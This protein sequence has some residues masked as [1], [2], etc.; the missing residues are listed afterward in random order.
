ME[1][2]ESTKQMQGDQI[3]NLPKTNGH[4]QDADQ[5]AVTGKQDI[6]AGGEKVHEETHKHLETSTAEIDTQSAGSSSTGTLTP[7]GSPATEGFHDQG[8]SEEPDTAQQAKAA[9]IK[10]PM[11]TPISEICSNCFHVGHVKCAECRSIWYCSRE[12]QRI[13]WTFHKHLCREVKKFQDR[14]EPESV[15]A[16]FF[17]ENDKA[18]KF[19]W[20]KQDDD[21]LDLEYVVEKFKDGEIEGLLSVADG[22][23]AQ[24]YVT[25]SP[26]RDQ[27]PEN[28]TA[29]MYLFHRQNL[30]TDGS[31][32][33]MSV[34]WVTKGK[35]QFSW[36]G[37]M[38][39]VLTRF[40]ASEEKDNDAM[41][42]DISMVDFRDLMDFFGSY[43]Q[44]VPSYGDFGGFSFFW[45][46]QSLK[47]ELDQQRRIKIVQ[48][49]SEIDYKRTG[50]KYQEGLLGEGHPAMAYLQP[51]PVTSS[52][53]LPLVLRR[54]PVDDE[55]M[56]EVQKN[57]QWNN[58]AHLLLLNVDPKSPHWGTTPG[59]AEQGTVWVM[60]HDGK[61]LY[62]YH[63]QT[64]IMYLFQ[65]VSEAMRESVE[66]RRSKG[67]VLDL[68]H[69]S[70]LDWYFNK[71]RK[72]KAEKDKGWKDVRPLFE[73]YPTL[74][75]IN[76]KLAG[77]GVKDAKK[78]DD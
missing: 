36:R 10:L 73:V 48:I 53:G 4:A 35:F 17:P 22:D 49:A 45:M 8:T 74:A 34:G 25:R 14:P 11:K 58:G 21:L 28:T 56:E 66:G 30:H 23:V 9:R 31:R 16:I 64:I 78:T 42:E 24:Q 75:Q 61:D 5:P 41:L 65:V 43:G 63:A 37:P 57:G 50:I 3:G 1:G 38:V 27:M 39:A 51:C 67:E 2:S 55:F 6:S 20:L 77:L 44:L 32:P 62:G 69:P 12:C 59:A 52:L 7:C 18:P 68:L 70:R 76:Q 33:N 40:D 29:R 60:R 72:E 26:R 71:F 54:R 19:V 46:P 47:D 13:D 15:R